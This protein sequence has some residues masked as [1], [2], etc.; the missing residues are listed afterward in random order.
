M[1]K[2]PIPMIGVLEDFERFLLQGI[3]QIYNFGVGDEEGMETNKPAKYFFKLLPV[4]KEAVNMYAL[5]DDEFRKD[6]AIK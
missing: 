4:T 5:Y 3:G 6:W 2:N 1:L